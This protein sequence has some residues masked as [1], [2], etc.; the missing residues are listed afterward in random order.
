[1]DAARQQYENTLLEL[2]N[3]SQQLN[4]LRGAHQRNQLTIRELSSMPDGVSACK[5]IGRM[6]VRRQRRR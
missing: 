6:Y 4:A 1:M 3:V 2:S 5:S